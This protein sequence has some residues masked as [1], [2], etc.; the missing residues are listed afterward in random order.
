MRADDLMDIARRLVANPLTAGLQGPTIAPISAGHDGD[1][2]WF[3]VTLILPNKRLL[4]GVDVLRSLG[5]TDVIVTPVRYLFMDHS[6]TYKH[7]CE[8]LSSE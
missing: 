1:Q 5:A 8:A 4:Q 2:S 7:L 3:T 6:P